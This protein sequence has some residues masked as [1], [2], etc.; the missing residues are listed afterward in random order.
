MRT[1]CSRS[2]F[3][4]SPKASFGF[5]TEPLVFHTISKGP[6]PCSAR[7]LG[8]DA[9]LFVSLRWPS[10]RA[11]SPPSHRSLLPIASGATE[12][13][14]RIPSARFRCH[15]KTRT[16]SSSICLGSET[17]R[18]LSGKPPLILRAPTFCRP[19][20]P[21]RR[22][23]QSRSIW[24]IIRFCGISPTRRPSIVCT[25]LPPTP[26]RPRRSIRTESTSLGVNPNTS[27]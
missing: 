7:S 21:M 16:S 19:H 11:V 4:C 25:S 15:G 5:H 9:S 20:L 26:H 17:D 14:E 10:P 2:A 8:S 18:L 23:M 22:V 27:M 12:A 6:L 13:Q 3:A 24:R 1:S